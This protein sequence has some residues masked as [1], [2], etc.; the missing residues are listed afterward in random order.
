MDAYIVGLTLIIIVLICYMYQNR[1][2]FTPHVDGT[3]NKFDKKYYP[4]IKNVSKLTYP[5]M[6]APFAPE[7][8]DDAPT[9]PKWTDPTFGGTF[10]LNESASTPY[11]GPLT[12][13]IDLQMTSHGMLPEKPIVNNTIDEPLSSIG[14]N[15]NP[16]WT[17]EEV[18][19]SMYYPAQPHKMYVGTSSLTEYADGD[20]GG[21]PMPT[22]GSS[23]SAITIAPDQEALYHEPIYKNSDHYA[24]SGPVTSFPG[25]LG[26]LFVQDH[27]EKLG[28]EDN[29]ITQTPE[30]ISFIDF[31]HDAGRNE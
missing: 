27:M 18:T 11:D 25:G 28:I 2:R 13:N 19:G 21:G 31:M 17:T 22:L 8:I 20:V 6:G 7:T 4:D 3:I 1:S 9:A 16:Y 12:Q 23:Q 26:K 10:K 29:Y 24:A 5:A 15:L 14:P 30:E